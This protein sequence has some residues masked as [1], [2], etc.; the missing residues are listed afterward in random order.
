[1]ISSLFCVSDCSP[2][3]FRQRFGDHLKICFLLFTEYLDSCRSLGSCRA[4]GSVLLWV[5]GMSDVV[6]T[7]VLPI[8]RYY[9]SL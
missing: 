9:C 4:T 5:V 7:F 3:C 1:M 8:C 6:V 2:R